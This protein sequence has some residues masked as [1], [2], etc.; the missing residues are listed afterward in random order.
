MVSTPLENP[1]SAAS[2]PWSVRSSVLGWTPVDEALEV[3]QDGERRRRLEQAAQRHDPSRRGLLVVLVT[4]DRGSTSRHAVRKSS[5]PA[6]RGTGVGRADRPRVTP[7]DD[8]LLA[9]RLGYLHGLLQR[10]KP[11]T[12]PSGLG[13]FVPS[14]LFRLRV[15]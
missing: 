8:A 5:R 13:R 3:A 9:D 6:G 10:G 11:T 15:E 4:D 1:A 7:D 12:P 2:A 14:G